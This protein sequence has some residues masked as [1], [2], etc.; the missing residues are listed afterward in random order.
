[1]D[2]VATVFTRATITATTGEPRLFG[3]TFDKRDEHH[4]RQNR[5]MKVPSALDR[6]SEYMSH[7]QILN[8][9]KDKAT[10]VHDYLREQWKDF[11]FG[12]VIKI[13]GQ[14]P[15]ASVFLAWQGLHN[16]WHLAISVSIIVFL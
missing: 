14:G 16:S 6:M 10:K 12:R 5:D 9:P 11:S 8:V 3:V 7:E 4:T 15:Y 1:M 2:D 13:Q